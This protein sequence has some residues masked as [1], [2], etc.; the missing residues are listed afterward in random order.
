[1][2]T[3]PGAPRLEILKALGDNTRYAIYLELARAPAPL[4]TAD[5]ARSLDLHPNTVRPH[6]ERMRELGLLEQRVDGRG[7]VG[8]PQHLYSLSP[9]APSLGLEPPAFPRLAQMLLR[10]VDASAVAADDA[11]DAGR[12]QG[13]IDA[14]GWPA[15]LRCEAAL[16]AELATLGFD[17]EQV[18]D[19]DHVTI[20]FMHCPF[21]DLAEAHPSVVCGLHR[22][23]VEGFVD[24][25]G[26][27][28]VAAF[29]SLVDRDH[30][31]QVDLVETA[32]GGS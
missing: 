30:P 1:V 27:A 7:G 17:P 28:R 11:V 26:G 24:E 31:C 15:A 19:D 5:I 22:G 2:S 8:R 29:R 13:R 3:R 14:A 10:L 23:M 25:R 20:G 16:R 18:F 6:L 12:E 32:V 21:R 9:D 4:A